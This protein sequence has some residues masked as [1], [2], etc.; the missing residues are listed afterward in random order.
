MEVVLKKTD[1]EI[2]KCTDRNCEKYHDE[3]VQLLMK[4]YSEVCE[5]TGQVEV[6]EVF[7]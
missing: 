7:P 5:L 3:K 1:D 6:R 2:V 4:M